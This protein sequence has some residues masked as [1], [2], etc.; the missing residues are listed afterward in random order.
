MSKKSSV[1][2]QSEL[3]KEVVSDCKT[4]YRG[5]QGGGKGGGLDCRKRRPQMFC[6]KVFLKIFQNSQENTCARV[7]EERLFCRTPLVVASEFI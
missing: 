4:N 5:G 7:S 3:E 1:D 2:H 6:K